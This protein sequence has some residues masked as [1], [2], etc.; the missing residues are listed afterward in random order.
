M[1]VNKS[2]SITVEPNLIVTLMKAQMYGKTLMA[3]VD[4]DR[5]VEIAEE[6]SK[7]EVKRNKILIELAQSIEPLMQAL[8]DTLNDVGVD[9]DLQF[10]QDGDRAGIGVHAVIH[11]RKSL[12]WMIKKK[13]GLKVEGPGLVLVPIKK[14]GK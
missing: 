12:M 10:G 5:V 4:L 7:S 8:S 1:I 9:I 13:L 11:A 2:V 3:K 14:E 6:N